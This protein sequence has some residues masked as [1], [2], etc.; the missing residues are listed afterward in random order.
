M[1]NLTA[2]MPGT[3]GKSFAARFPAGWGQVHSNFVE[4]VL[5]GGGVPEIA[6]HVMSMLGGAVLITTPDGRILAVAGTDEALDAV[7][8]SECVEESGRFR[9]EREHA[10]VHEHEG[11]VGNH[12]VVKVLA[13][14]VDHG[15]MVAHSADGTL[16]P[17]DVHVLE[18]A[19]TVAALAITK[20]LAVKAVESKYRGDFLRELLSGRVDAAAAV[21]HSAS[22]GWDVARAVTVLVAEFDPGQVPRGGMPPRE[23]TERFAAAWQSTV[24]RADPN[25]PVIGFNQ[26]VVAVLGIP[27]GDVDSYVRELVRKVAGDGGGGRRTFSTGVSC[28]AAGPAGIPEAYGQ[29]R[30]ALR[31]GRRV[32]GWSAVAHFDALGVFRLLSLIQDQELKAYAEEILGPLAGQDEP[33][34]MNLLRTLE[35]LFECNLNVAEAARALHFHYNTL[36]QR[37]E[38][39]EHIVGPFMDDALV[40]LNVALALRAMEMRGL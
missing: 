31:V 20:E 24:R 33:A 17:E 15:R 13:G 28:P 11:M 29:A 39:L 19:A 10:G 12:A 37:I 14:G 3:F 23:A 22:L 32:Y 21:A 30:T 8:G 9:T 40:R 5:A 18:Q 26:E 7:Y 25:A 35:V 2:G 38:K 1:L 34:A 27:Y 36:R 4:I 6:E 16:G